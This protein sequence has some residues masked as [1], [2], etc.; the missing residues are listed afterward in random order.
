MPRIV[1]GMVDTLLS[2]RGRG[3]RKGKG[4]GNV[5]LHLDPRTMLLHR[6]SGRPCGLE[7][8][9]SHRNFASR[10]NSQEREVRVALLPLKPAPPKGGL[11]AKRDILKEEKETIVVNAGVVQWGLAT[12]GSLVMRSVVEGERAWREI[13]A[14]EGREVGPDQVVREVLLAECEGVAGAVVVEE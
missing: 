5:G 9:L 4:A 12:E 11:V 13:E 8:F 6:V 1:N 2:F 10:S 14:T 3:G 7:M